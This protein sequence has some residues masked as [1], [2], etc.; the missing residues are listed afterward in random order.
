MTAAAG[1]RAMLLACTALVAVGAALPADAQSPAEDSRVASLDIPAQPVASALVAFS[2]QTG[3][4]VFVTSSD[5]GARQSTAVSGA[6]SPDAALARLL[7]GTGLVYE[8]SGNTV[9]VSAPDQSAADPGDVEN[10]VI[11][12]GTIY[13]GGASGTW[14]PVDGIVAERTG[15]GSKTD[16]AVIDIPASVSVVGAEEMDN[17]GVNTLDT[18][19]AYTAGVNTNLYGADRRYDFV[20]IRGFDGTNASMYR[21]GLQSRIH[22]FTGTRIETYGMERVEVMKGSTSTLYGMNEPGGMINVI[23]KRPLDYKFGEV[24]STLGDNHLEFGTDFGGPLDEAG[25]WTYRL[26]A[27]WQESEDGPA[28]ARDDRLYIAPALTWRPSD[29]TSITLMADYQKR[30]GSNRYGIPVGSGIDPETFLGEPEFEHNETVEKNIGFALEHAF[31]SGLILRSHGRYSDLELDRASTYAAN[32][33]EDAFNGRHAE[34]IDGTMERWSFDTHLQYDAS[35]GRVNSRTLIGFDYT[36]A[37]TYDDV[38]RGTVGSIGSISDP[39]YC[40]LSCITLGTHFIVDAVEKTSGLYV[41]EELTI[42][43][44]WIL[45]LGLRYDDVDADVTQIQFFTPTF[46]FP[47]S[48]QVKS[49]ALTSRAG[50]TWKA[51]ED[52]SLYATYSESF[53]PIAP[54]ST[55]SALI[56]A[57]DPKEGEMFEIGV[58]Y[59]PEGMNALFTAAVYDLRQT[60]LPYQTG[61]WTWAQLGEIRSRGVELEARAELTAATNLA[62]AYSYT[63]AEIVRHQTGTENGNSPAFVPEHA[64]SLWLDHTFAGNGAMNDLTIG[65]GAR[66]VGSRYADIQNTVKLPAHAVFDA[67]VHYKLAENTALSVNIS[68]LFDKTYVSHVETWSN[69]DT[70]FYGSG[71]MIRASLKHRW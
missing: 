19:L 46:S 5:A 66:Y 15:T 32:H 18:A 34:K 13:I 47:F 71:R 57:P 14:A 62:L 8:V 43:D 55:G 53:V 20:A 44:R 59:R 69:P 10:G 28:W 45:T 51:T 25:N 67:A 60:N 42:D 54:F 3:L 30:D 68:N 1:L 21:D 65:I 29:A 6:L 64:A 50:L 7:A 56:E 16:A 2:R 37:E 61:A 11:N 48:Q 40:G 9:T 52:L 26:T 33:P 63:D 49:H 41:Q 70:A 12:L 24:Y 58:K 38:Y 23:T 27:K 36:R 35:F 22:N 31:D 39:V 17:R 4:Q